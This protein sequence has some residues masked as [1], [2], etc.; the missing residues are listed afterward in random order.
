[1]N[2]NPPTM[3]RLLQTILLFQILLFTTLGAFIVYVCSTDSKVE[4]EYQ[5]DRAHYREM[6]EATEGAYRHT[7]LEYQRLMD[8]YQDDHGG[9]KRP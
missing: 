2:E 3:M 5:G 4:K 9:S 6:M 7:I 1:M 8:K